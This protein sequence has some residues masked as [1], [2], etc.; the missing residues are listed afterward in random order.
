DCAGLGLAIVKQ[1]VEQHNGMISLPEV[2][3]GGCVVEI[4]L[5]LPVSED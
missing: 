4:C 2:K 5:P 3:S 1:L